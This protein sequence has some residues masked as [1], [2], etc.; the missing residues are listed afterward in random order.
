ML[1]VDS[2]NMGVPPASGR[3]LA[4]MRMTGRQ[5]FMAMFDTIGVCG[6]P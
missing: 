4:Q 5:V 6:G 2:I 3:M 1:I